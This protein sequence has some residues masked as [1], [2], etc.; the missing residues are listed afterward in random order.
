MKLTV[1]NR[2]E[3]WHNPRKP[4]WFKLIHEYVTSG[5]TVTVPEYQG[6]QFEL[7]KVRDVRAIT[8]E[9]KAATD[10]ETP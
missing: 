1:A 8:A 9:E 2:L 6:I 10:S 7:L 3:L 4:E 5:Y